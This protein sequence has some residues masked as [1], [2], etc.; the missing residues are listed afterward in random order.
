MAMV[1]L[2]LTQRAPFLQF[3]LKLCGLRGGVRQLF[4]QLHLH[5]VE[6]RHLRPEVPLVCVFMWRRQ[7]DWVAG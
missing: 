5:T 3:F 6:E 1:P 7:F 2:F 4:H